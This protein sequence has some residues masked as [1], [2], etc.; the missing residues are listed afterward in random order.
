VDQVKDEARARQRALE[1]P[2]WIEVIVAANDDERRSERLEFREHLRFADITEMPD[3][4]GAA[5][6]PGEVR[7]V[8]V[9]GIGDHGN[10]HVPRLRWPW[11][12]A[13]QNR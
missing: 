9:V 6:P 4:V 13:T 7:R 5:E 2:A 10:A 11:A 1:W 3:L 8:A 12:E